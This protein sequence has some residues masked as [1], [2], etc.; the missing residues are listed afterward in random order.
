MHYFLIAGEASGDLHAAALITEL[1]R[2]DDDARFTFLGGDK[3]AAAAGSPPLVHY[4][5]MAYMGFSEV[6]R[7]LGQIR[8][9]LRTARRALLDARPDAFIA[10][11][12]PS[13]NLKVAATARKAGIPV[14]YYISPKVWAWKQWRVKTIR[15]RVDKMLCILP[16]EEDFYRQRGVDAE[17]VGNPSVEEV[18]AALAALGPVEA[19]ASVPWRSE[20]PQ[21]V[22]M[23]GSRRGEIRCNLPVMEA[24]VARFPQYRVTVAG[25]PGIEPEYYKAFTRRP[26]VF[27]N[28]YDL[29][30]RARA[31]LVTSGTATLEAALI[32]VPQVVMYRSNGSRVAY[33]LMSRLLHVKYVALPN[34]IVDQEIVTELLL[35]YCSPDTVYYCLGRITADGC[36]REAALNGYRRMRAALGTRQA[37]PTAAAAIIGALRQKANQTN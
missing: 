6:L 30:R 14:Y 9:N 12:Y 37:A 3:M 27:G 10:V 7:H 24:A 8:A 31:A 5:D 15:R 23:P 26:V 22:L 29:L 28:T 36:M 34:L 13:F 19:G 25:A 1:R 2:L 11:D 33:E 32:G 4:R 20:R 35:H 16:F 21:I 18:D 17:Y